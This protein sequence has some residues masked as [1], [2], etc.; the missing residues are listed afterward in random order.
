MILNIFERNETG[1]LN[2]T[3]IWNNFIAACPMTGPEYDA[4]LAEEYNAKRILAND[5]AKDFLL[6]ET[7]QD[8]IMFMLKWS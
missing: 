1:E 8:M 5:V 3:P 2:R 4:L 6:F 7:E